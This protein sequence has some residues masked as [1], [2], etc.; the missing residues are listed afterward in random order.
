MPSPH[1]LDP[2]HIVDKMK[3]RRPKIKVEKDDI[4]QQQQEDGEQQFGG[5]NL[6]P[7]MTQVDEVLEDED[8]QFSSSRSKRQGEIDEECVGCRMR[9]D[10]GNPGKCILC[11]LKE[12]G[13]QPVQEANQENNEV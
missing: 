7:M 9:M 13:R 2:D 4:E 8:G 10:A 11:Q 1:V 6:E 5:L 12:V 3:S